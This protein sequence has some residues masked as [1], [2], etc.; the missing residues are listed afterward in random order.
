[1]PKLKGSQIGAVVTVILIG[2]AIYFAPHQGNSTEVVS[3]DRSVDVKINEAVA[4]VNEGTAPMKGILMLREVLEEN[5]DNI[6]AHF[7]LGLLSVQSQQFDKALDRFNK[8]IEL[9]DNN[10]EAYYFR[11]HTFASLGDFEKAK[12]DF[13]KVIDN[14]SDKELKSEAN[15]FLT[16]LNNN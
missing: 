13:E 7:Q 11:A 12:T 3:V 9:D 8:V 4:I 6:R 16:E 15:K 14:T 1:M 10:M 5:P 2:F